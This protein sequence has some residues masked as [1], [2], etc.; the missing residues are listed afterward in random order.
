M[1]G[2]RGV[3]ATRRPGVVSKYG[4]LLGLCITTASRLFLAAANRLQPWEFVAAYLVLAA[5]LVC[6]ALMPRSDTWPQ[7]LAVLLGLILLAEHGPAAP[8]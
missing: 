8:F 3:L 1:R 7:R 6:F 5:V 2:K 4:T